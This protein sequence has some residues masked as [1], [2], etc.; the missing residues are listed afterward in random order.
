MGMAVKPKEPA[1]GMSM[2]ESQPVGS[3][4]VVPRRLNS[5]AS[6]LGW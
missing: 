6:Q 2:I 1:S 4:R 3:Y 5:S